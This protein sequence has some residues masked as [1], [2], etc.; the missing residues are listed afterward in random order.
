M[1]DAE[2]DW[3]HL[4]STEPDGTCR[5]EIVDED[6]VPYPVARKLTPGQAQRLVERIAQEAHTEQR[7]VKEVIRD[8]SF[9]AATIIT[10]K[11]LQI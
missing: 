7:P 9:M 3:S 10:I 1:A 2:R 4:V 5:V 8:P 6:G 11:R